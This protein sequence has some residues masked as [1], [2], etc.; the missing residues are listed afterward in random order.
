M[1]R[2]GYP[3]THLRISIAACA[4]KC[5]VYLERRE[6][7]PACLVMSILHVDH[8]DVDHNL[9]ITRDQNLTGEV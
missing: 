5:C 6:S 1:L 4:Q 7:Q 9:H 8:N 2:G 3:A